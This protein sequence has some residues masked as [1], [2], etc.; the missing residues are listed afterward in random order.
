M[1]E[2]V[3]GIQSGACYTTPAAEYKVAIKAI[4]AVHHDVAFENK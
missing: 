1:N 4:G 3:A 2:S